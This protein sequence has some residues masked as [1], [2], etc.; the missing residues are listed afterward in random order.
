MQ[1]GDYAP[2]SAG[3]LWN[4]S[5]AELYRVVLIDS[6]VDFEAVWTTMN[7]RSAASGL[8]IGK[9]SGH[10]LSAISCQ[11]ARRFEPSCRDTPTGKTWLRRSSWRLSYTWRR[12]IRR[13]ARFERCC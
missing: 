12:S 2:G 6:L 8:V 4:L 7:G 10:W 11:F 9:H 5:G 13:R 1:P 3:I